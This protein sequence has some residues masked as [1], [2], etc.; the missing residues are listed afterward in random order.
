MM[1]N[2]LAWDCC[3][4]VSA[5]LSSKIND[6]ASWFHSGQHL[7]TY[8]RQ[9]LANIKHQAYLVSNQFGGGSS[10]DQCCGDHNVYFTALFQEQFHFG[11]DEFFGHLFRITTCPGT[12]F[13]YFNFYEFGSK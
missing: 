11:L 1:F 3:H 2:K 6:H 7:I 9:V 13:F 4:T 5:I 10:W 8:I 12:V